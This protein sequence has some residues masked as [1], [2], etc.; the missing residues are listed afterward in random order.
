ML[1][2]LKD[3]IIIQ[4]E[5]FFNIDEK[6]III[7]EG[8]MLRCSWELDSLIAKYIKLYQRE[9]YIALM[10]KVYGLGAVSAGTF[11]YVIILL[12]NGGCN[13]YG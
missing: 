1:L 3:E 6:G 7:D 10:Y 12:E 2:K 13:I 9:E 4:K 8:E 11:F 5:R